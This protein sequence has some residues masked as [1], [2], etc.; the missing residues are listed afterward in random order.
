[1]YD[2]TCAMNPRSTDCEADTPTTTL[3]RR[4]HT[5]APVVKWKTQIDWHLNNHQLKSHGRYNSPVEIT[6]SPMSIVKKIRAALIVRDVAIID[7]T[8][9]RQLSK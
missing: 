6:W 3:S 4:F 7:M 5:I 9:T 8:V 1:M 2:L